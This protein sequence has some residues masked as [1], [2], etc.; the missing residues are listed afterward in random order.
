ML[1]RVVRC[2]PAPPHSRQFSGSAQKATTIIESHD[3][4]FFR[5]ADSVCSWRPQSLAKMSTGTPPP[6]IAVRLA[7]PLIIAV[8]AV[9]GRWLTPAGG[10]AGLLVGMAASVAGVVPAAVSSILRFHSILVHAK[11]S[12][13]PQPTAGQP[14]GRNTPR[15][16]IFSSSAHVVLLFGALCSNQ[17]RAH[18]RWNVFGRSA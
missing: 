12:S 16:Q 4:A 7:V 10:V 3:Q 17:L 6:D 9:L 11:W 8:L 2:V 5:N 15:N 13:G 18:D 14:V 1:T